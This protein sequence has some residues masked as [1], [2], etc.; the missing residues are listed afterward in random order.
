MPEVTNVTV[1]EATLFNLTI[2]EESGTTVTLSLTDPVTQVFTSLAEID[3]TMVNLGTGLGVYKQK[4]TAQFIMRSIKDDDKTIDTSLQNSNNEI[5]IKLP[6]AGISTPD[7]FTINADSDSSAKIKLVGASVD[8]SKAKLIT[9][10]DANSQD[11]DDLNVLNA[12]TVN[13]VDLNV[14]DD[15][16]V[17][18]D[19][20]VGGTAAVTGDFQ[21]GSTMSVQGT[22]VF[23]ADSNMGSGK[24]FSTP[25]LTV[26]SES[27]INQA[28]IATVDINAGTID[29]TTIGA[30]TSNTGRFSTL[31]SASVDING[32]AIDGTTIGAST[33]S[34][35][36]TTNL[37][38]TT[39][40]INAGTID[41]TTI[42]ASTPSTI[43]TTNLTATTADING[44]TIDGTVVG[45]STPAAVSTTSLVATT[46]DINAGTIDNAVIGASTS[47][48]GRFTT[49]TG[50][51]GNITTV[52]ATDVNVSNDLDVTD[53]AEIGG[54]LAVTGNTI[55]T[56]NLTVNGTTT[57][58]NTETLT[59]DDNI[60]VLNNNETGTPSANGGIE[61]ERG[62]ADNAVLQWTE[63]TDKWE[64]KVG[65]SY[66][67]IKALNGEFTG[68]VTTT[69]DLTVGGDLTTTGVVTMGNHT[70]L[71][72][73]SVNPSGQIYPNYNFNGDL[74]STDSFAT[75]QTDI[76]GSGNT[77]YVGDFDLGFNRRA[78][79]GANLGYHG[80]FRN[81]MIDQLLTRKL[82]A[83][84]AGTGG[85]NDFITVSGDLIPKTDNTESLGSASKQW[86]EVFI[87]PGSLY[88]D[89]HKVL[90]SSESGTINFSTDTGQTLDVFAGGA[91][92]TAGVINM[93]SRGNVTTFNDTTVNLGPSNGGATIN[94]RGTLEAPDLHVGVLE[95]EGTLINQTGTDQNLEVRTNGTGYIHLKAADVYVGPVNGAVK[96]DESSIT[97]TA[98]NLTIS[99]TGSVDIAGHNTTS[100]TASLIATAKTEAIAASI[101][102]VEGESTLDLTG[103][104]KVGDIEMS[105]YSQF[106][107]NWGKIKS[108][109]TNQNLML[110]A[111]NG[112]GYFIVKSANQ[113]LGAASGVK[114]TNAAGAATTLS[115]FG[116][117]SEALNIT[118]NLTGP[119]HGNIDTPAIT[120]STTN[121]DIVLTTNGTGKFKID[122][123]EISSANSAYGEPQNSIKAAGTNHVLRLEANNG[124]GYIWGFTPMT[125]LGL[126]NSGAKI[127]AASGGDSTLSGYGA[128]GAGGTGILNIDVGTVQATKPTTS[129]GAGSSVFSVK[130]KLNFNHSGSNDDLDGTGL[131]VNYNFID[132]A[133]TTHQVAA[134]VC[135][136][137]GVTTGGSSGSSTITDY[138]GEYTLTTEL[139]TSGSA[140]GGLNAL[141]TNKDFTSV[142]NELR[143]VNTARD[144]GSHLLSGLYLTNNTPSGN[145]QTGTPTAKIQ[146]RNEGAGTTTSLI[147]LADAKVTLKKVT[148]LAPHTTTAQN[149]LTGAAGDILFNTTTSKFMG[150]NGSAWVELG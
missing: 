51:T 102:A 15:L 116:Y 1:T 6:D 70:V 89:G 91:S 124:N 135:K 137:L 98:G 99:A 25:K 10:L 21:I 118:G 37:T 145:A 132:E 106:N 26:S 128:G 76:S 94:A 126:G 8:I 147:E 44:G 130:R 55:L 18:D 64:T 149:A 22:A 115:G 23:N 96:I 125:F 93:G 13:T 119:V 33:P 7:N 78:S 90:G 74:S 20:T 86:K 28:T 79:D 5:R 123:L 136:V 41:G 38:A 122:D 32:G 101:G 150:Y 9:D 19:L 72:T 67:T 49:I 75:L 108:T 14:S 59:V 34:T 39:A 63:G 11:I 142:T 113:Y 134:N 53:D 117:Q 50:T 129:I 66:A 42:G 47:N 143:V 24:R 46:A 107:E 105:T 146:L 139:M 73:S 83:F 62:T 2:T 17:T 27:T 61:I 35:I 127:V 80:M 52:N 92:G 104:V 141:T 58:V 112:T 60:I 71:G 87:G 140:Q 30:S 133:G 110:E 56:G 138:H 148:K 57:T 114:I 85:A 82:T 144:S 84:Q 103:T 4:D 12:T 120:T 40:D 3:A 81:G 100:E 111:S 29:N 77:A 43:V 97:T 45:G 131:D 36:V 31:E 48:T 68:E 95:F 16:D 54:D 88:I 121:E 69:G 65:S 109:G